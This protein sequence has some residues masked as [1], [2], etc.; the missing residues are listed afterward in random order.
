MLAVWRGGRASHRTRTSHTC[1][2]TE[3]HPLSELQIFRERKGEVDWSCWVYT[4]EGW[5]IDNE[6]DLLLKLANPGPGD[7][8]WGWGW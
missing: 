5:T 1:S 3:L 7:S 8:D 6:P 4:K 2:S